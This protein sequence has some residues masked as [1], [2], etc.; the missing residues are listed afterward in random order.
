M[1]KLLMIGLSVL[2]LGQL[3]VSGD[4]FQTCILNKETEDGCVV[5]TSEYALNLTNCMLETVWDLCGCCPSVSLFGFE[6]EP[7]CE[8]TGK[9]NDDFVG[10][11][12]AECATFLF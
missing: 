9:V 6:L 10:N 3:Y 4:E 12:S 5:K 1:F 11:F 2:M 8:F 7:F